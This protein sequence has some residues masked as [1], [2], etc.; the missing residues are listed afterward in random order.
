MHPAEP[1][2]AQSSGRQ[3]S[4]NENAPQSGLGIRSSCT[5]VPSDSFSQVHLILLSLLQ[6]LLSFMYFTSVLSTVLVPF[7]EVTSESRRHMTRELRS[8]PQKSI[9]EIISNRRRLRW[10]F[11]ATVH[12]ITSLKQ[13]LASFDLMTGLLFVCGQSPR[14]DLC[15]FKIVC[16]GCCRGVV[17]LVGMTQTCRWNSSYFW[18]YRYR[19]I[20][21]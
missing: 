6:M 1:S 4:K 5:H 14:T 11:W 15:N 2:L 8:V 16:R 13:E 18:S 9:T 7:T 21:R 17:P 10:K 19:S 12:E 3:I 20:N